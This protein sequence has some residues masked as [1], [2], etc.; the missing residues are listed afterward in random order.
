M[1]FRSG[2]MDTLSFDVALHLGTLI[3]VVLY[4]R[5]DW[6]AML[7]TNR[8]LFV[9]LMVATIPA[10]LAGYLLN[11]FAESNLRN[12]LIIS[13]ALIIVSFIMWWSEKFRKSRDI[14]RLTV[15]DAIFI[16][17]AQIFALIPGVSRSGITISAGLARNLG[18]E[19]ATRFSFL[20]STPIIAGA[21]TLHLMKIFK[22][23]SDHNMMV[24]LVGVLSSAVAG[25]FA[26]RFLM[27]FFKKHSLHIFVYYRILLGLVIM[28]TLWLRA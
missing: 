15:S 17:I 10:G 4:F 11:D 12:P 8:K 27:N 19:S 25:L 14:D 20:L 3:A 18:R 1:L 24:I 9:L 2:I 21:T 28:T 13:V 23:G 7:K 16:G 22:T 5:R 6:I 26:I